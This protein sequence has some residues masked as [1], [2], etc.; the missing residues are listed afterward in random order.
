[1]SG[2]HGRF[3]RF[4]LVDQED[5]HGHAVAHRLQRRFQRQVA[6]GIKSSRYM[7]QDLLVR[8]DV[9]RILGHCADYSERVFEPS[10]EVLIVWAEHHSNMALGPFVQFGPIQYPA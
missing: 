1:M 3:P 6:Y 10:R 4:D 5:T 9:L 8:T 2:L 7:T